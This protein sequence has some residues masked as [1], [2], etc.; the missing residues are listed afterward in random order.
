MAQATLQ[1][2]IDAISTATALGMDVAAPAGTKIFVA[3][4]EDD[5]EEHVVYVRGYHSSEESAVNELLAYVFGVWNQEEDLAPWWDYDWNSLP[6]EDY[7]RATLAARNAWIDENSDADILNEFFG[8][9]WWSVTE[10]KIER[11]HPKPF[12]RG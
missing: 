4:A 2:S 9:H 3:Y 10:L 6:A 12:Q 5:E 1:T 11:P 8:E 7:E